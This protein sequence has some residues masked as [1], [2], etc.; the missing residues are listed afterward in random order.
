MLMAIDFE[1]AFDSISWDFLYKILECSNFGANFIKWIKL[2]NNNIHAY[3]IQNG[4]LS[5]PITFKDE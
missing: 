4:F 5:E 2:L 3:I 1:K